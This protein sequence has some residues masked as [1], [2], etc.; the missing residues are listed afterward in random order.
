MRNINTRSFISLFKDCQP[1]WKRYLLSE[2]SHLQCNDWSCGY[3]KSSHTEKLVFVFKT[4]CG[5][6]PLMVVGSTI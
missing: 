4:K 3:I 6:K 2:R 5:N 1:R